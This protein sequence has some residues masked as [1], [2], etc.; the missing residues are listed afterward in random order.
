MWRTSIP[1]GAT[2]EGSGAA[3]PQARAPPGPQA[4]TPTRQTAD[5]PARQTAD[6]PTRTLGEDFR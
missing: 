1:I 6:T 5:T 4:D 2:G 3:Y